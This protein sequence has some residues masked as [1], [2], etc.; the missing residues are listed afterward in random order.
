MKKAAFGILVLFSVINF[1][2]H[3]EPV[4]TYVDEIEQ[5][6]NQTGIQFSGTILGQEV[7]W[8]FDNWQNNIGA[9]S[10][11]YW[12][13][14]NG[15]SADTTIQRRASEIY[16]HERR[17]EIFNLEVK[18]PAFCIDS[19]YVYKKS[20]FEIGK[21]YFHSDKDPIE[22]GFLVKIQSKN[23]DYYTNNGKQDNSTFE[24]I[25]TEE[26][27]ENLDRNEQKYLVLWIVISCNL[28]DYNGQLA[29]VI[30]DGKFLTQIIL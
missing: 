24:I 21:K 14:M 9:T 4:D 22:K 26:T 17:D 25:K 6:K 23:G 11:S 15:L 2:C 7:N 30:K 16:D 8:K 27:V 13:L 18:S 10:G 28:Y 19:S 20:L 1:S 3:K 5:F 29:G 12:S